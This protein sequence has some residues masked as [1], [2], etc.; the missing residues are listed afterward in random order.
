MKAK[1]LTLALFGIMSLSFIAC[2]EEAIV[3][4]SEV[5]QEQPS[6]T[7]ECEGG[8]SEREGPR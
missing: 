3:P 8:L 2:N 4:D 6:A 1:F 5:K 7:C